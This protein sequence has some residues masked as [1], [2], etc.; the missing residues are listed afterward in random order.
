MFCA[1]SPPQ[2]RAN[3]TTESRVGK[4]R[5]GAIP[6]SP[7]PSARVPRAYARPARPA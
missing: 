4:A 2:S 1:E 7:A 5:A 3:H 6:C